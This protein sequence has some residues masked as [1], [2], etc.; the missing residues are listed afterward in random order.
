MLEHG[1]GA[2]PLPQITWH[3]EETLPVYPLTILSRQ[4]KDGIFLDRAHVY[5]CVRSSATDRIWRHY[6]DEYPSTTSQPPKYRFLH[7]SQ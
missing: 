5:E 7:G 2:L 4:G 3:W 1:L 6:A